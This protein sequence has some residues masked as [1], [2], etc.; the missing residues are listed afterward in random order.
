M[1]ILFLTSHFPYPPESGA[2]LK[3]WSVFQHL[4]ARHEINAIALTRL[5]LTPEQ[6]AWANEAGVQTVV[7]DRRRNPLNLARSYLSRVPLS[8]ERNE[9]SAMR[10]LVEE[11]LK[12]SLPDA[13]FV[14]GWLVAQ[15]LPGWFSGLKVLHEHNAEYRIWQREAAER[16]S[17]L[18]GFL[19]RRE[20]GRVR[21]YEASLVNRFD[22]IFAVSEDDR[23]SLAALASDSKRFS[24][25]PNV[26]DPAL[27]GQ[28][29]LSFATSEPLI[30]Y[31]GTLSWQPNVDGLERFITRVLPDITKRIPDARLA[32]A[33]R[34]A[35]SSL[36]KLVTTSQAVDFVGPVDD[37]E[38]L[39][40]RA[41]VFVEATKTG[42]GT[43]LK[44]L[45]ALARGVPVV[46]SFQAARGLDVVPG[47]HL[48]VA[49]SDREIANAVVMLL[50]DGVRWRVL[51][52]NG[53]ALIRGKYIAEI[54]F[55]GLDRVL[56]GEPATAPR[57]RR[58]GRR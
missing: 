6:Q 31:F 40:T 34:D 17:G 4:R 13:V 22:T 56:G 30:L 50:T 41:R 33:G 55:R 28:P 52:E 45:N 39:Y 35:P 7:L 16:G 43:R 58:R 47:D 25:L 18:R 20:A 51:S 32:V 11:Q 19:L 46:A 9:S 38:T 8:V 15:Y 2:A 29:A 26:P 57:Q 53:R 49:R 44:V 54:A 5:P 24:I 3:T 27:L 14:D 36:V 1:R 21:R 48:I 10:R 37:A 12:S 42:G 23:R